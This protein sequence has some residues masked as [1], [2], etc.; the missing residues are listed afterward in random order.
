[1]ERSRQCERRH[2]EHGG[3]K[4]R[5]EALPDGIDEAQQP[6]VALAAVDPGVDP[7]ARAQVAHQRGEA[8][9]SVGQVMED[10]DGEDEVERLPEGEP[11]QVR[12]VLAEPNFK[13]T[14]LSGQ[15]PFALLQVGGAA[16]QRF[17]CL[18]DG[19]AFLGLLLHQFRQLRR[20]RLQLGVTLL[21]LLMPLGRLP[22]FGFELLLAF[23]QFAAGLLALLLKLIQSVPT[24]LVMVV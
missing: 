22:L 15:C 5:R 13:V 7:S 23:V 8:L 11:Q 12:L 17:P 2:P 10:A 24:F 18:L 3:R 14:L 4:A 16:C 9:F 6:L 21:L 1:M 19:L 20:P